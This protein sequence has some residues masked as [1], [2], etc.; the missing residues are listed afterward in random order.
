[1]GDF[2]VR[3]REPHALLKTEGSCEPFDGG[4]YIF[5]QQIGCNARSVFRGIQRHGMFSSCM[6]KQALP[7]TP[8]TIYSGKM[9][10]G[11][12]GRRSSSRHTPSMFVQTRTRRAG[13]AGVAAK[14]AARYRLHECV[15]NHGVANRCAA[16]A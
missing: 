5:I 6:A 1:M 3:P 9:A 10:E 11:S 13:L 2:S 8:Q 7:L 14:T 16:R 12:A 4:S 15:A